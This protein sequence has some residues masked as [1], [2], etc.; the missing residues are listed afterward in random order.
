MYIFNFSFLNLIKSDK[1]FQAKYN[2]TE[3]RTI[4][5]TQGVFLEQVAFVDNKGNARETLHLGI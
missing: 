4:C 3:K 5:T 2:M 1:K